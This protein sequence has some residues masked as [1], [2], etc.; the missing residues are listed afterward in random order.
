MN[1]DSV[2]LSEICRSEFCD[3][4]EIHLAH[5]VKIRKERGPRSEREP[6]TMPS[7]DAIDES[8]VKAVSDFTPKR[9]AHLVNDVENDFGSLG[10]NRDSAMRR[11]HRRIAWLV[12]QG[13]ILRVD[14]GDTLCTYLKP[15]SRL[16]RDVTYLRELVND[17]LDDASGRR[18]GEAWGI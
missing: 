12:K 11:L 14:L 3:R 5:E 4:D 2:D 9:F 7:P 16:A 8:I 15:T 1:F 10:E 13:R 17:T 18:P 6:W